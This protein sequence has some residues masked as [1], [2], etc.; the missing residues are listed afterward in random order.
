MVG[1]AGCRKEEIRVYEIPKEDL[2]QP[3]VAQ[4]SS[5][6]SPAARP[7]GPET[8][9]W[10]LPEGWERLE[11]TQFRVGNFRIPAPD[12]GEPG[13]VSIVPLPGRAGSD[14]AN[15]NRW[16]GQVGLPPVTEQEMNELARPVSIA[17]QPAKLFEFAGNHPTEGDPVRMLAAILRRGGTAWFFKALGPDR[18][19][20]GQRTNF[21]ALLE[22][23]RFEGGPTGAPPATAAA[24]AGGSSPP[25]AA[26]TDWPAPEGWRS[27]PPGNMQLAR[28]ALPGPEGQAPEVSVAVLGGDGGGLLA[29][30]NRWRRQLGLPPI[31][32]AGLSGAVAPVENGPAGAH[33]VS[34]EN[35]DT[36]RAMLAAVLPAQGQTWFVKMTGSPEAVKQARESFLT[37]IRAFPHGR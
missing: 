21:L 19:I 2:P 11:P 29:N 5:P 7:A 12:G 4:A 15:V 35:P 33:L 23:I 1:V 3:P 28:Y 18:L 31:D 10:T 22:S 27:L 24:A 6:T 37:F 25:G 8:V 20:A 13:E 17:G 36:G 26:A 14:L 9:R 16:R 34:L 30:V 32:E